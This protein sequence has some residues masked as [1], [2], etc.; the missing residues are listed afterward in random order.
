MKERAFS[1]LIHARAKVGKT[2]LT[3][4][5]PMPMLAL[6]AE[7]GW[8]YLKTKGWRGAPLVK[9]RWDPMREAPPRYDGTWDVCVVSVT[10]WKVLPHTLQVLT[11]QPHDFKTVD[12]DSITEMQRRCKKNLG[13]AKMEYQSWGQLLDEMDSVIRG[14]RDLT[15][16]DN[17]PVECVIFVSES[18]PEEGIMRPTMQGQIRHS[19]PF[20]VDVC[21]YLNVQTIVDPNSENGAGQ[22]VVRKLRIGAHPQ[23]E[24]GERVQGALPDTIDDPNITAMMN[25]I[26]GVPEA[27]E[28]TSK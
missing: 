25:A 3:T 8:K 5:A 10:G 4:T 22:L 12:L 14:F 6:D 23:V 28:A 18:R 11:Q 15:L 27:E 26:F 2:T 9:R 1:I 13:V 16:L 17:N 24:S 20:W 19:L 7:G 21:G